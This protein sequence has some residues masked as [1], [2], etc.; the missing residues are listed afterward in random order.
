MSRLS[1]SPDTLF[2][3]LLDQPDFQFVFIDLGPIPDLDLSAH[4]LLR[5][6]LLA[7]KC[8][9]RLDLGSRWPGRQAESM[10]F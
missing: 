9:Y 1:Q 8:A 2:K 6:G 3:A 5:A 4:P 10:Y 7:L